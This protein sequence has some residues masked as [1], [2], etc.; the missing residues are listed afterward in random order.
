MTEKLIDV[1]AGI[2]SAVAG[3]GLEKIGWQKPRLVCK[4]YYT[5][6]NELVEKSLR[7]KYST[8]EY[9]IEIINTGDKAILIDSFAL[10]YKQATIVDGCEIS[11]DERCIEPNKSIIYTF[12][13][14]QAEVLCYHCHKNNLKECDVYVDII[15][16]KTIKVKLQVEPIT[17]Q[18]SIRDDVG[19]IG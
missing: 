18:M 6:D 7:T 11:R 16:G 4:L 17:M 15:G 9:G 10:C 2:V 12:A 8:S 14:Q 13:Q 19:I 1:G 3:K 5:P